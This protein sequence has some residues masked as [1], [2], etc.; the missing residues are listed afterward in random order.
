[1]RLLGFKTFIFSGKMRLLVLLEWAW[2]LFSV[3]MSGESTLSFATFVLICFFF[4]DFIC[5]ILFVAISFLVPKPHT[6][7]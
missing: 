7:L 2:V 5:F 3:V 6:Q 1:M 4:L